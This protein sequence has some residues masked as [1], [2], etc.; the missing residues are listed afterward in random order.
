MTM[1]KNSEYVTVKLKADFSDNSGMKD[2]RRSQRMKA[3]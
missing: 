1:S 2:E 3:K